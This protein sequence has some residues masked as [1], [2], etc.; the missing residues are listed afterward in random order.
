MF[1]KLA[2]L[3]QTKVAG[4]PVQSILKNIT[5][6]VASGSAAGVC[7]CNARDHP[8]ITQ[9]YVK[10]SIAAGL[11]GATR[12]YCIGMWFGAGTIPL[13]AMSS[14][15]TFAT[16]FGFLNIRSTMKNKNFV[17]PQINKPFPD[18]LV[19]SLSAGITFA[20]AKIINGGNMRQVLPRLSGGIVI[21]FIGHLLYE[22]IQVIRL[23]YLLKHNYSELVQQLKE[24]EA[25]ME[26]QQITNPD[27]KGPVN[28]RPWQDWATGVMNSIRTKPDDPSYVP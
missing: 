26:E 12:G 9:R 22:Q 19:S 7:T 17:L 28:P 11:L 10:Y 2:G 23:E 13:V 3:L 24:A 6:A 18:V 5:F 20:G 1:P 14:A 27:Y 8:D 15:T 25:Y 16:A 4:Q 21:G